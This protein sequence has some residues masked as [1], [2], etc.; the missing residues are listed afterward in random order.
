MIKDFE[1]KVAVVTGAA[2]GIGRSLAH[3][4]VKREMK[5]VL[6]DIDKDTLDKVAQDLQ[7]ISKEVLVKVTDVSDKK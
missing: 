4:F 5:V 2:H 3:A 7:E 6:A 1:G